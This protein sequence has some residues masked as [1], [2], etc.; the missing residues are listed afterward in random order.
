MDAVEY[1]KKIQKICDSQPSKS[2]GKCTLENFDCGFPHQSNQAAL[3][4]EIVEKFDF[5]NPV[6]PNICPYCGSGLAKG[7][8]VTNK[9][10]KCGE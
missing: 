7:G 2:C 8:F 5:K 10:W 9:I 3:V 1:V 4:V 6:M